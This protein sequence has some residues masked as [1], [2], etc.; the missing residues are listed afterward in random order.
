MKVG[1]TGISIGIRGVYR[2]GGG[3][4]NRKARGNRREVT[5]VDELVGL[6]LAHAERVTRAGLQARNGGFRVLILFRI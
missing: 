6:N 1:G 2:E 3:W 5:G 4:S